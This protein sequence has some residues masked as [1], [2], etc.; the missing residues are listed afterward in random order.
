[1]PL[2]KSRGPGVSMHHTQENTR[3]PPDSPDHSSLP[4]NHSLLPVYKEH[5]TMPEPLSK[6]FPPHCEASPFPPLS[7]EGNLSL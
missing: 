6:G 3:Q 4:L 1:M 7:Q 5:I 2:S